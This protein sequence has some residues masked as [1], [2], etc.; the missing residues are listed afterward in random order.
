MSNDFDK[1]LA[2]FK[3]NKKNNFANCSWT[4]I[5]KLKYKLFFSCD[6]QEQ[7]HY[8]KHVLLKQLNKI[9][10]EKGEKK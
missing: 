3:E 4:D 2:C 8:F 1:W 7:E 10:L 5:F 9:L 6:D